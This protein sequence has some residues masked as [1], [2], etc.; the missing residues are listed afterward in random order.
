MGQTEEQLQDELPDGWKAEKYTPY[1]MS[2]LGGECE[3]TYYKRTQE[4]DLGEDY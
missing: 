3:E 4:E 2:T 1:V